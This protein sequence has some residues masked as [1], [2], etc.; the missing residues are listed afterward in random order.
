MDAYFRALKSSGYRGAD[1]CEVSGIIDDCAKTVP[2]ETLCQELDLQ[3]GSI[4]TLLR[5]TT[6]VAYFVHNL[7]SMVMDRFYVDLQKTLNKSETYRSASKAKELCFA[8]GSSL[9]EL[10]LSAPHLLRMGI[11]QVSS[12]VKELTTRIYF[13]YCAVRL[14]LPADTIGV[15]ELDAVQG[16]HDSDGK[17][18][19]F[20]CD[21]T[22]EGWETWMTQSFTSADEMR[23]WE[24]A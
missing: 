14:N 4:P 7:F 5:W 24:T 2:L 3:A 1:R 6:L 11:H 9:R 19:R 8:L 18:E 16:S 15:E 20:P 21:M 17:E 10:R 13:Y 22:I 23:R 12:S